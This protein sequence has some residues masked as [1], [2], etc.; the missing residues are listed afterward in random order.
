M[1]ILLLFVLICINTLTFSQ[2]IGKYLGKDVSFPNVIGSNNEKFYDIKQL[3]IDNDSSF[4]FWR[5]FIRQDETCSGCTDTIYTAGIW[6][7][8][9]DTIC[10]NSK[11][12]DT[13]YVKISEFADNTET[14]KFFI[15]SNKFCEFPDIIMLDDGEPMKVICKDTLIIPKIHIQKLYFYSYIN[16]HK[17]NSYEYVPLNEKSNIFIINKKMQKGDRI[18]FYVRNKKFIIDK[19]KLTPIENNDNFKVEGFY[20]K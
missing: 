18:N 11:Y 2:V 5:T 9:G 15:S 8:N 1:K 3:T 12:N 19:N 10:L 20:N 6:T 13:D 17:F 16:S 14:F 7:R 4:F